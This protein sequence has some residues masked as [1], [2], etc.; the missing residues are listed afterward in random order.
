MRWST[1][2]QSR[3]RQTSL[4]SNGDGAGYTRARLND[5]HDQNDETGDEAVKDSRD[6]E[7]LE[8]GKGVLFDLAR[9]GSE[10]EH[11]DGQRQR[12][13]LEDAQ[14]V[15]GQRWYDGAVGDGDQHITI[16]LQR[17]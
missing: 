15:A 10:L 13:I 8:R 7:S 12:G 14:E 9:L 4:R 5:A 2:L 1:R 16:D 11:A 6:G 17:R 3:T